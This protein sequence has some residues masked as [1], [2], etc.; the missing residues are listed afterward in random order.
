MATRCLATHRRGDHA[1]PG[2]ISGLATATLS[3]VNRDEF[4]RFTP[5][6]PPENENQQQILFVLVDISVLK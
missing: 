2:C 1:P 6:F 4:P 5:M 3:H